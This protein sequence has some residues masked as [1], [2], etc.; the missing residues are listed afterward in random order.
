MLN[1]KGLRT[2]QNKKK[3]EISQEVKDIIQFFIEK[4]GD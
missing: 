4:D 3:V 1:T 2:L